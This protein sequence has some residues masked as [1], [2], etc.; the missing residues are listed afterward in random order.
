MES[1]FGILIPCIKCCEGVTQKNWLIICIDSGLYKGWFPDVLLGQS[2]ND[3]N[4][5]EFYTQ[6]SHLK[7]IHLLVMKEWMNESP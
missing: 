5:G 3:K 1:K 6:I 2:P 7:S 4:R